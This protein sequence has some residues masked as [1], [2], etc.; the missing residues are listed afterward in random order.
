[1]V[2]MVLDHT[3]D[4]FSGAPFNP[5]DLTQTSAAWFL[6]RWITHFCAPVFILLAGT[7]AYMSSARRSGS[8]ELRRFLA[9]RGFWLIFLELTWVRFAWEFN[10]NYGLSEL[11]VIWAIGISMLALALVIHL[12]TK[13]I[14]AIGLLLVATHN[15][16]DG[17]HASSFGPLAPLWKLLHEFGP[18]YAGQNFTVFVYYPVLPWIGVM[19]LGYCLGALWEHWEESRGRRLIQ[20]GVGMCVAFVLLRASNF[21]GDPHAWS[22]QSDSVITALS[23]LNATKYPP[24]LLYLLMTLGPA[25]ITLGIFTKIKFPSTI[26]VSFGRVPLFFYL[27]HIPFIHLIG[28]IA[29]GVNFGFSAWEIGSRKP[30]G[31]GFELWGVYLG[32]LIAIACL[33]PLSIWFGNLKMRK[34]HPLLR[35]L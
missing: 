15:L 31:I 19:F 10:V 27:I 5:T 1:M 12:N 2:F 4:F 24:S 3:R 33:Y 23:F 32:A 8:M 29:V 34:A 17:V 22:V 28:H 6:T 13:V 35:F 30:L 21:Y 20:L 7:S 26:L 11:G 16:F 14:G 18:L 9:V 25:M